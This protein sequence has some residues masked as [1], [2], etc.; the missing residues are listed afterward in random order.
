MIGSTIPAP[1]QPT[2]RPSAVSPAAS[3]TQEHMD[4]ASSTPAAEPI[5]LVLRMMICLL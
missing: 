5:R 3:G 1:I 2:A 4:A